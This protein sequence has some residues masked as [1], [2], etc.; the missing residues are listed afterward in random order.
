MPRYQLLQ[1]GNQSCGASASAVAEAELNNAGNPGANEEDAIY[2]IVSRNYAAGETSAPARIARYFKTQGFR[3]SIVESPYRSAVLMAARP[4]AMIPEWWGYSSELWGWG[5]WIWRWPRGLRERDFKNNARVLLVVATLH[6]LHYLLA[7]RV[8]A[9]YYVMDPAD[10]TDYA[11][12]NFPSF[13]GFYWTDRNSWNPNL[14]I[15]TCR[16]NYFLGIA[17]WINTANSPW[18]MY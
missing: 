11:I 6:G 12:G 15:H 3:A 7:R 18:V 5:T 4:R 17:V 16:A 10:G 1:S 2:R 13:A 14:S 8:G 9:V